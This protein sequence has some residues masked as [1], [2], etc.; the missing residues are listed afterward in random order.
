LLSEGNGFA[1]D[2]GLE[3]RHSHFFRLPPKTQIPSAVLEIPDQFLPFRV[4]RDGRLAA[5]QEPRNLRIQVLKLCVS[6]GM[7]GSSSRVLRLLCKAPPSRPTRAATAD[8]TTWRDDDRLRPCGCD[9]E[10]TWTFR[11]E[12]SS[13]PARTVFCDICVASATAITPPQPISRVSLVAHNRRDRSLSAPWSC[14]NFRRILAMICA[15]CIPKS[16][17]IPPICRRSNSPSYFFTGPKPKYKKKIKPA[18]LH[19]QSA[20]QQVFLFVYLAQP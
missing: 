7:R 17:H 1:K 12:E 19:S 6:V 9:R 13:T 2:G 11:V 8:H 16:S 18:D 5:N 4:Y 14:R 10:A 3:V 20:N 15:S